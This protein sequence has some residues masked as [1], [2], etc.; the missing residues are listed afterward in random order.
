HA[1]GIHAAGQHMTV[2][3]VSGDDLIARLDRHLHA[4]DDGFLTD[5]EVAKAADQPHAVQLSR[6]LLESANEQHLAVGLKLLLLVEIRHLRRRLDGCPAHGGGLSRWSVASN[7]HF[8]P[9]G[10]T[11]RRRGGYF[12]NSRNR[13][14]AEADGDKRRR[15]PSRREIG[16][17]SRFRKLR[18]CGDRRPSPIR[19]A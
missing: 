5:I 15:L 3:A 11:L 17:E 16:S 4:D 2:V 12:P 13:R 8:S 19:V 18:G 7:G 6:L 10:G 14:K 1:L 9:R